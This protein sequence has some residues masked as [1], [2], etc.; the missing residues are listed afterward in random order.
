MDENGF[1][2]K[3][4][5]SRQSNQNFYRL[6]EHYWIATNFLFEKEH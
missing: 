1:P 2:K 6:S 4:K 3:D 5:Y